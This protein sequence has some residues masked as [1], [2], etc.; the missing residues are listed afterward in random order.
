MPH[1]SNYKK[2]IDNCLTKQK[3][4]YLYT[5]LFTCCTC[6]FE[7][8]SSKYDTGCSLFHSRKWSSNMSS[9]FQTFSFTFKILPTNS[10]VFIIVYC[11]FSIVINYNTTGCDVT[12]LC[13]TWASHPDCW[14]EIDWTKAW[15]NQLY[16]KVVVAKTWLWCRLKAKKSLMIN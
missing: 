11:I 3:K 1:I 10:G 4:M 12:D 5:G 15:D 7:F 13:S 2:I 14:N 16:K 9:N 8:E 6:T